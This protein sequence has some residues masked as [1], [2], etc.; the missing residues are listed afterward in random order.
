VLGVMP[1]GFNI[2]V[3]PHDNELLL[4][5]LTGGALRGRDTS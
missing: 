4:G 5:N 1:W 3:L 2:L